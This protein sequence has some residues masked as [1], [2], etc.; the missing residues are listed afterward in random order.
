MGL[1]DPERIGGSHLGEIG[2]AIT[3]EVHRPRTAHFKKRA[4]T[5]A[6]RTSV[7]G[8]LPVVYDDYCGKGHPDVGCHAKA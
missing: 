7:A 2:A 5:Q 4:I 6:G 8:Y 3:R 1:G